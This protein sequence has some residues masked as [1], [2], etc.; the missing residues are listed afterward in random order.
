[1]VALLLAI[2]VVRVWPIYQ[3]WGLFNWI[4]NDFAWYWSQAEAL[5]LDG[6][7][8][9]YDPAAQAA[10][11]VDL[12]PF[13]RKDPLV[14]GQVPY[15]PI[16]ALLFAPL[17]LLPPLAG[18]ALWMAISLAALG[19]LTWRVHQL[20]P[21]VS[22]PWL[23]VALA[24]FAPIAMSFF[25]GQPMLLLA[26]AVGEMYLALRAGRDLRA[27][28]WLS[29]LVLKP[30]YA[31]LLGPMLLVQRRWRAVGGALAGV[32]VALLLSW[33]GVGWDGLRGYPAALLDVGGFSGSNQA[34]PGLM[35]NWR[36][37]VLWA[38]P[39]LDGR[40]GLSLTLLLGLATAAALV[41][42]WRR[43]APA[44]SGLLAVQVAAT[45]AATLL[46]SYHSNVHGG[47]LL[48][49]PFAAVLA[50]PRAVVSGLSRWLLFLTGLLWTLIP[51]GLLFVVQ[52]TLV[53][54]L[55]V[56]DAV[57]RWTPVV[58]VLLVAC[59]ATLAGQELSV[60]SSQWS[61][62]RRRGSA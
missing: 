7:A 13:A 23:L 15:L 39:G 11:L 5:R 40:V 58:Q 16:F 19:W 54:R 38:R 2:W 26:V 29:V 34:F 30:Q 8:R 28:L 20:L 1:M 59:V 44:E 9:L 46:A 55:P 21:G 48:V 51:V 6:P 22:T 27:G 10:R 17:T 33:L 32:A 3:G 47:A 12:A 45:T 31:I 36:S 24:T 25:N 35:V 56:Q 57:L 53:G 62:L 43:R 61:V 50:A 42:L 49:V 4:G 14:P 41:P 18:Y 52:D 60:L 37:L